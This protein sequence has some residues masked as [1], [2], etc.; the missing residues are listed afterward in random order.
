MEKLAILVLAAGKS[1]RM[2]T[3]KQ[4]LKINNKTLIDIALQ[5]AKKTSNNVYCVLGANSE[6]IKQEIKSKNVNFID[7]KNFQKGLSTSIVEGVK[8]LEKKYDTI[9]IMLADQPEVDGNLLS[10][11][12]DLHQKNP[13]QIIATSY[14]TNKGVP[15]IFPK[16]YYNDLK[17]LKDDVGAKKIINKKLSQVIVLDID[18]PLIDLDNPK[19]YN[20]YIAN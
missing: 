6:L 5:E 17:N 18:K 3:I 1:S 19:D 4:L 14:K 20:D 16:S 9:L 13:S 11:L 7:N 2:R 10:R 8:Y 15:A 12:I